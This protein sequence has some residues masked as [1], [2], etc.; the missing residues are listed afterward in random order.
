MLRKIVA[1]DKNITTINGTYYD[2]TYILPNL[3]AMGIP[4]TGITKQWRNSKNEIAEYLNQHHPH[5]YMIWNLTEK[6]YSS[7]EFE[8]RVQHVGFLDH[9]PP[10][11][12]HLLK[13]VGEIVNFLQ[14]D[15]NNV[16]CV[17]CKAGRGRTGLVCSCVLIGLGIYS[18]AKEAMEFFAKRR[19]KINK[20]STSPPQVR[21]CYAFDYYMKV[22]NNTI[23]YTPI[24]NYKVQ[25]K[26]VTFN[27]FKH[28]I[29]PR[30]FNDTAHPVLYFTP[31]SHSEPKPQLCK[32]PQKWVQTGD[33]SFI[34]SF[35]D[36]QIV[37]DQMVILTVEIKDKIVVLGKILL[38][39]FFIDANYIYSMGIDKLQDPT[40]GVNRN[41]MGLPPNF[42][43]KFFFRPAE[44]VSDEIEELHSKIIEQVH[45]SPLDVMEKDVPPPLPEKRPSQDEV[46]LLSLQTKKKVPPP[47]PKQS[48][49]K[50]T[51]STQNEKFMSF[52]PKTFQTTEDSTTISFQNSL[53]TNENSLL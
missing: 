48:H 22:F 42:M 44:K 50:L 6:S 7:L 52:K 26:S 45:L 30:D 11:F 35:T 2:L 21:Y 4:T 18:N 46:V 32:Y 34:I 13:V 41:Q 10:R 33:G 19:S 8:N 37:N 23:P 5:H 40:E 17:H 43:M 24:P 29:V 15:P 39:A 49:P 31:L 27:E 16:A 20:G 47:L 1:E 36:R 3:I 9:H 38:P 53:F 14:S 25:L 51:H 12:N 28:C